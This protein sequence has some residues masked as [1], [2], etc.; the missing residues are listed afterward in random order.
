MVRWHFSPS[1]RFFP[2]VVD[3]FFQWLKFGRSIKCKYLTLSGSGS[4]H[5]ETV[6]MNKQVCRA[7]TYH[8]H[9][10]VI[11]VFV[12]F[13]TATLNG[14]SRARRFGISART[15][16]V[17]KLWFTTCSEICRV[18]VTTPC[19]GFDRVAT[20]TSPQRRFSLSLSL[21]LSPPSLSLS[22]SLLV[23]Q[24]CCT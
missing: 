6:E 16:Y 23:T 11:T 2:R 19:E 21:S 17:S 24:R 18:Y 5:P 3:F 22:F 1:P 4:K 10:T 7:Y 12:C 8:P 9:P 15:L 14:L 13:T 20:R